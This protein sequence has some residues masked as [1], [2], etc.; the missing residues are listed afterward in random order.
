MNEVSRRHVV[1]IPLRFLSLR[2][3]WLVAGGIPLVLGWV[4]LSQDFQARALASLDKDAEVLQEAAHMLPHDAE[5]H[6]QLGLVYLLDPRFLNADQAL[7]H[8]HRAVELSPYDYNL[9]I[10]LGR[11]YE[12]QGQ[13]QLATQSYHRAIT[14]A[15]TY[16]RPQW[17][18]ANFL[19][20]EGRTEEGVTEFV[21]LAGLDPD[22]TTNIF[23]LVWQAGGGN[24]QVMTTFG[25][26]LPSD[27]T[28]AELVAFLAQRGAY[29]E[30]LAVWDR[31]APDPQFK[32]ESGLALI[33]KLIERQHWEQAQPIWLEVVKARYGP[34]PA[35][36]ARFWNRGFE[37][38]P[39]TA[40][41]DW[42]LQST[43]QVDVTI[44]SA[45][46]QAGARALRLRFR[47][48]DGVRFDGVRH[49]LPVDPSSRYLLRFQYKTEGSLARTGIIVEV[50]DAE[51]RDRLRVQSQPLRNP[52]QWTEETVAFETSPDTRAVRIE[53]RRQPID[54]LHDY[55]AGQVWFDS[56]SLER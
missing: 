45:V 16:F 42:F 40:G 54:L 22:A 53:I 34:V 46:S 51:R 15:P 12:Q 50:T 48:H 10:D 9:W 18:Y 3:L 55:I 2:L 49:D 20:R 21:H 27:R 33:S 56:F 36:E 24:G 30:A 28:R 19:L 11:A 17:V 1:F 38:D 14:I 39:M 44:D 47:E 32:V 26:R 5:L 6:H 35:D 52:T 29:S 4:R 41:F 8:F 7:A 23:D 31:L 37:R 25:Q 13:T 43:P